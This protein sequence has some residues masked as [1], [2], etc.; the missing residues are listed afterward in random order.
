MLSF[1]NGDPDLPVIVGAAFNSEDTSVLDPSNKSEHVIKTKSG[2]SILFDDSKK[3]EK[4][5]IFS[6]GSSIIIGKEGRS[7]LDKFT[8]DLFD[9]I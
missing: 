8:D 3:K 1:V 6:Q 4:I 9:V 5:L 7:T 2:A